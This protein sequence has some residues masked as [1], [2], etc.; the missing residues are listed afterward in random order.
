MSLATVYTRA[1]VA[2]EAPKVTVEIHISNGLP[3]LSIV[4]LPE[5]AVKESKDRVRSALI[6]SGFEFPLRRITVNLAPVDLPKEGGR[7][8]LPI[9]IGVLVASGQLDKKNISDYEFVGELSLTGKIRKVRGALVAAIA[10][11]KSDRAIFIPKENID[12]LHFYQNNKLFIAPSL[13]A[14]ASHLTAKTQCENVKT[15]I[16]TTKIETKRNLDEV[17]GQFKA[18]RA[19]EIAA[20]GKHTLLLSGPPGTG[21]TLLAECLSGILPEM[22]EKER[23]ELASLYSLSDSNIENKT[24]HKR[25][26]R[27]PHHTAS[28]VAIVGGGSFPKPGEITLAHYGILFLDEFPE[29]DKKVIESLRQPLECGEVT[30]SRSSRQV[31]Y[32]AKFQLIAAMNPC[33]CGYAGDKNKVC[34]CSESQIKRYRRK[35][36]GPILDRIDLHVEVS[37]ISANE[38]FSKTIKTENSET[39]RKRV[40]K[41]AN[42]QLSR[43]GVMNSQLKTKHI[44]Q[45]ICLDKNSKKLMENAIYKMALSARVIHKILC[46]ARTIA[47]IENTVDVNARQL[48]EALSF[49]DVTN[50]S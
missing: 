29:F 31:T 18:R 9:A 5:T 3:S 10:A 13:L 36:S 45:Q 37:R 35:I 16:K 21:K 44:E 22:S 38:I 39:V 46:V 28:S 2:I 1:C 19:L 15:N 14:V 7:Y 47:D 49:R 23:L 48:S 17:K 11:Q 34:Q 8:D 24:I 25:P 30:I 26:F 6:N 4:G 20:A 43:Q 42:I 50:Y 41:A 27:S 32:P 33:P 12:E 40:N